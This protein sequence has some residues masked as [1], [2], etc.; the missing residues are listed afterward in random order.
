MKKSVIKPQRNKKD[1]DEEKE[2][3]ILKESAE[4]PITLNADIPSQVN[5][6]KQEVKK[7]KLKV[8]KHSKTI[9]KPEVELVSSAKLN[10]GPRPSL[11]AMKLH[12]S[13]DIMG[14]NIEHEEFRQR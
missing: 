13:M 5:E 8:L 14:G 1:N 3:E 10:K 7:K 12:S 11:P 2:E 4:A 9:L 6:T